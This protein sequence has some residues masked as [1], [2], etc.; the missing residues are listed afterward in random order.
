MAASGRGAGRIPRGTNANTVQDAMGYVRDVANAM[1]P[2]INYAQN[3]ANRVPSVEDITGKITGDFDTLRQRLNT[4][5]GTGQRGAAELASAMG[6]SPDY[7]NAG[8]NIFND[9][10][11]AYGSALDLAQLGFINTA[12]QNA[13]VD[14]EKYLAALAEARSKKMSTSRDW[15]STYSSLRNLL[16]SSGYGGGGSASTTP[17]SPTG[18]MDLSSM[19]GVD[20]VL[21]SGYRFYSNP[22]ASASE[23]TFYPGSSGTESYTPPPPPRRLLPNGRYQ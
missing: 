13:N 22:T 5:L 14:R 20:R 21:P 2:V 18:G 1:N 4:N 10:G 16:K 6:V 11:K 9:A 8:A 23:N 3:A 7:Y 15:L 12:K 19:G 17:T